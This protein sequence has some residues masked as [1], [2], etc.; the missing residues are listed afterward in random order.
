MKQMLLVLG[1]LLFAAA[2]S[3]MFPGDSQLLAVSGCCKQRA[4]Y[5]APWY[6]NRKNFRDCENLNRNS[7]GDNVFDQRGLV[8]WDANC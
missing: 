3:M 1:F 6:P 4:S 7:D 8:W 2:F 5:G